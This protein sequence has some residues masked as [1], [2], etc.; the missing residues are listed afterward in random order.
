MD[1]T[2]EMIDR[3]IEILEES[4]KELTPGS[5][6]YESMQ[7]A[8]AE[9]LKLRAQLD[10]DEVTAENTKADNM[11]DR[12]ARVATT[13]F[14]VCLPLGVYTILWKKGL[15]FEE[16]GSITSSSM[17]NLVQRFKFF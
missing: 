16:T 8:I 5:D 6:E 12:V 10:H 14:S 1:E 7:N 17:R 11:K 9:M 3:R 2:R 15:K 4:I 13:V